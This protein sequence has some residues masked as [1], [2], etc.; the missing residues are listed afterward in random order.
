LRS[1]AADDDFAT[2]LGEPM[3]MSLVRRAPPHTLR[4]LE[5]RSLA[6]AGHTV[7]DLARALGVEVPAES[8]RAKGFVGGL[9]E[10][11]LGADPR[12]ADGPD[13]P[14]LGVELKTVPINLR[15]RPQESTFCCGITM[16]SA[17]RAEWESSRLWRR[18]Q[19][20]L[21]VPVVGAAGQA[22]AT[23]RFAEPRLWRPSPAEAASLKA[24]W[25]DLMGAIGAGAPPS[26]FAG[27]VLQVRPKG[28]HGRVTTLAA[29]VDGPS[30]RLPLGFYLRARFTA[31]ILGCRR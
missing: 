27:Q 30:R 15:G 26:A 11:A 13:F 10:A 3:P 21:W 28:P 29:D 17:D 20:V 22:I 4:E 8:R 16:H 2:A 14:V 31:T 7:L 19:L 24:D 9:V 18:L 6:L 5:V 1:F 23:K 12:A 25:E